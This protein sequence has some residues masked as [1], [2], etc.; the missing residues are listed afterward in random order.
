MKP[1]NESDQSSRRGGPPGSPPAAFLLAQVGAHAAAK[2][3]G[4]LAELQLA[5]PHAGI[6]GI[7]RTQPALTQQAL[8]GVLGM[9]PSRLVA[10]VDELET[11]ALIERRENSEDR[12]SYALHLTEKGHAAL[13][14]IGRVGREHQQALLTALNED[15]QR[16]LGVLLKRIADQQGLT[17]GVHPGYARLGGP[18]KNAAC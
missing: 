3:A 7:L 8:A 2:F 6:M 18:G 5:P 11:R 12:R 4:R 10:L 9:Q 14:A 1:P 16:Q 15:E 17:P 13:S